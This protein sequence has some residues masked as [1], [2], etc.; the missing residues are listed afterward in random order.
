MLLKINGFREI[1]KVLIGYSLNFD[2]KNFKIEI[3]IDGK[4]I[5]LGDLLA[6]WWK[7][8]AGIHFYL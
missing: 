4:T 1:F 6:F 5:E 3:G 8:Y 2:Y 7:G